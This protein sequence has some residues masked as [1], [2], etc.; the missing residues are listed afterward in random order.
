MEVTPSVLCALGDERVRN[1]ACDQL[2][3]DGYAVEP[4][5]HRLPRG[6]V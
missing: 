4:A 6:G 1:Y 3:A 5:C 2:A